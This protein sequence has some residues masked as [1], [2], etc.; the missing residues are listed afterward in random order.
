[1][2][3]S[4]ALAIPVASRATGPASNRLRHRLDLRAFDRA[5]T[6][7][8]VWRCGAK[9]SHPFARLPAVLAR[10]GD[11]CGVRARSRVSE[12]AVHVSGRRDRDA[13]ALR[14]HPNQPSSSHPCLVCSWRG[15]PDA[16]FTAGFPS[17][18]G[19]RLVLALHG[20]LVPRTALSI[21]LSVLRERVHRRPREPPMQS[22][23]RGRAFH[24]ARPPGEAFE[25]C[26]GVFVLLRDRSACALGVSVA[27]FEAASRPESH[28]TGHGREGRLDR[29]VRAC[30]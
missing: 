26:R 15:N 7:R 24:D 4:L 25:A 29:S 6:H 1:M 19:S 2:P 30:S 10:H 8:L 18:R 11:H 27:S 3:A 28:R 23:A 12:N 5:S 13:P 20:V 21:R 14:L 16:I 17:F 22:E 9:P